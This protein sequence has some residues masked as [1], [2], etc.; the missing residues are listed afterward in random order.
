MDDV[1]VATR[2][3]EDLALFKRPSSDPTIVPDRVSP[4]VESY[5]RV[6][7]VWVGSAPDLKGAVGVVP[8]IHHE[9]V[10]T[11]KLGCGVLACARRDGTF[12]FDF[13]DCPL[14]PVVVI[15]GYRHPGSGAYRT[16]TEYA[17]A[18]ARAEGISILRAQV[19]NVH[20]LCLATAERQVMGRTSGMG[21]PVTA[22]SAEK[23]LHIGL[24]RSYVDDTEDMHALA[25]NVLNNSYGVR[26]ERP[27]TRAV[28]EVPVVEGSFLLL[29]Q[30]LSAADVRLVHIVEGAFMAA[31]RQREQ[32]SGEAVVLAWTVCEQLVSE[33]WKK[34][35]ADIRTRDPERISK[36]RKEKLVGRDFT[37]SMMVEYLELSGVVDA[38]LYRMLEVARRARNRWAHDM[39][40]PKDSEVYFAMR[41]VELLLLKVKGVPIALQSGGRG[42]V[43]QWPIWMWETVQARRRTADGQRGATEG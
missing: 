15:P 30:I 32:R 39:K 24:E 35:V 14:A 26:R 36:E 41:A 17:E 40:T 11:R 29:D 23:S 22:W 10:V 21:F 25:R 27:L 38:K 31:C 5:F 16:P 2:R 43:P 1:P 13:T 37:A 9:V 28:V 20:Q 8:Q 7:P 3:P 12:V 34:L 33:A 19:M 4:A 6:P 18:E 42:G